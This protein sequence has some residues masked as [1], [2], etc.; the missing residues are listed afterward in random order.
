MTSSLAL[1]F[2]QA[3]ADAGFFN[4]LVEKFNEGG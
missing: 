3:G 2:L 4:V 1:F